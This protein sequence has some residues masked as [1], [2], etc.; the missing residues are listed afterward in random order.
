M[1]VAPDARTL[2]GASP[3][4]PYTLCPNDAGWLIEDVWPTIYFGA[5]RVAEIRRKAETLPW[6]AALL[7]RMR[8]EAEA[9][10]ASEEPVQPIE[11]IGW[12]HEF[13]SKRT[14]EHLVWEPSSPDAF[15]DPATGEYE[16]GEAEHQ[17]WVL[18]THERT[19]RLMRGLGLVY[20]LTGDERL[21]AWVR[22]GLLR[23]VELFGHDELREGNRCEALY[24]SSLYDGPALIQLA[25]AYELTR[26]SAAYDDGDHRAIRTGIFE[27][28]I[29]YQLR[30][31][32]DIGVHNMA[33]YVSNAV[34]TCGRVFERD[35]WLQRG[36]RDPVT[37]LRNLLFDGVRAGGDGVADGFWYEGTMF[38]HFYSICP[39]VALFELARQIGD[40]LADDQELRGR[41]SASLRAP[42]ELAD[43]DDRLPTIGDLGCPV[44]M[45]LD[46]YRHLYEY[47]AGRLDAATFGPVAARLTDRAGAR[48]GWTALAYGSDELPAATPPVAHHTALARPGLVVFREAPARL[49]TLFKAGPHGAGHDHR[50]KLELLL[51]GLGEAV[52]PDVGTAG[53][54]VREVH[55]YYRTT[56]SHSTLMVDETEQ[57]TVGDAAVTW[58]FAADPAHAVGTIRDAYEGVALTRAVWFDPPWVVVLDQAES[59]SEHRYGWLFHARGTLRVE[60]DGGPASP[61]PAL[62][63]DGVWRHF[64][65][66]R[67]RWTE[68]L[69]AARWR[70]AE[71]VRLTAL[72]T[73]DGA[74]ELTSGRS[75]G[76]PLPDSRGALLLRAPGAR[77]RFA[78]VFEIHS[79]AA[80][81]ASLR[82]D[83]EMVEVVGRTGA[84]K[85][86]GPSVR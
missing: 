2:T 20:Q 67:T 32:D 79:G 74:Y 10:C 37:G 70:V 31:L 41:L 62:P 42:L 52:A 78:A 13:Y 11:R 43:P 58:D 63:Q 55:P 30:F 68:S 53:Y 47:A 17:A 9:I 59:A 86:Y 18:L 26:T 33:C 71:T 46:V 4:R 1:S 61:L 73:S 40:P 5:D 83:G 29:P 12:R 75:A 16:S 21:A 14:A 66:R 27:Q 24:F 44:V 56:L 15:Y 76:Q 77:R 28:G 81:L 72:V 3:A 6:A 36:L 45:R 48:D 35:D 25:L 7:A 54:A 34:A 60:A 39:L 69:A 23:A 85:R 51:H 19:Q 38:Y 22:E 49:Y 64:G 65:A 50:D 8:A 82:L 57:N 84:V 80:S